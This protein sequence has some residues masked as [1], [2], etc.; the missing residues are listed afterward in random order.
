MQRLSVGQMTASI[1]GTVLTIAL[2]TA[3]TAEEDLDLLLVALAVVVTNGVFW[4]AHAHAD[5]LA[6]RYFAGR[7]VKRSEI[8]ETLRD[9]FPMVQ[10]SVPPVLGLVA[11][12]IGLL[13][14]D[15]AVYLALGIGVAELAGWGIAT[16]RKD[17]LGPLRTVGL[18]GLNV[19]LGLTMVGLK[20][21][22]H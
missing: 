4:L 9:A 12:G 15:T 3:Y 5:L 16:G 20:L 18:I 17:Q 7:P 2:I 10:A 8:S 22:I 21:L 13:D 1:Y 14:D 11:G 6:R 19:G